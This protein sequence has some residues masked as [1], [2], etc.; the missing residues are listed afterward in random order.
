MTHLESL[1]DT[2]QGPLPCARSDDTRKRQI[3]CSS[4]SLSRA[5]SVPLNNHILFKPDTFLLLGSRGLHVVD[6][7]RWRDPTM[8][9]AS[10]HG[11]PR[12]RRGIS[13]TPVRGHESLR[14]PR[15]TRDYH[16]ERHSAGATLTP[17]L[18][19]WLTS[20]IAQSLDGMGLN[21]TKPR[22]KAL[23]SDDQRHDGV[24]TARNNAIV[25][26]S[27]RTFQRFELSPMTR[28]GLTRH[29]INT[30]RVRS[31]GMVRVSKCRRP[32]AEHCLNVFWQSL[33]EAGRP[34]RARDFCR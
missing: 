16:A 28:S 6:A 11:S 33:V 29:E 14:H 2:N 9:V 15:Q 8:A 30:S 25:E 22:M 26:P 31:Q 13:G 32:A 3:C 24:T 12:S 23:D 4:N 19:R 17:I 1:D 27:N 18:G 5:W 7:H 20:L 21:C 10:Y 34:C